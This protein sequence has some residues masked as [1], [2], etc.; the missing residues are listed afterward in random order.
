MATT[1]KAAEVFYPESDGKPMAETTFH[2]DVMIEMIVGLKDWFADDPLAYVSG[3]EFLYFVEGQPRRV[4]SPDVWYVH[5]IDKT[6]PRRSYKTWE[7]EG[8]GPDFVLEVS[9]RSTRREDLVQKFQLYRD[10]LKVRE[11]FLFDPLREYLKPPFQGYRLVEGEYRPIEP[12][13]GRLP[14]EVLGLHLEAAGYLLALY[15]P[16]AGRR[17]LTRLEALQKEKKARL[18]REATIR[19]KNAEIRGKDAAIQQKDAAIQQKDATLRRVEEENERLRQE[20][21]ALRAGK[22]PK[23]K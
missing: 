7:D 13:A 22:K 15:D 12:V 16:A 19:R 9:S 10:D 1:S 21:E 14:S 4:V 18:R 2:R 20:L 17:L 6:R 23:R 11:Y 3:N 8:K 5:G